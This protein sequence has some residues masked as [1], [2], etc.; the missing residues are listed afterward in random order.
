MKN[1]TCLAMLL[2]LI[3]AIS[4]TA[5]DETKP[6][7]DAQAE[8]DAQSGELTEPGDGDWMVDEAIAEGV[9]FKGSL[10]EGDPGEYMSPYEAASGLYDLV[11]KERL[12]KGADY[13]DS[14]PMFITCV[15][16]VEIEGKECYLLSVSGVFNTKA[17]EYGVDYDYD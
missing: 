6:G 8:S 14:E 1:K 5:C 17:W 9:I 4:L 13:S 7:D 16:V 15:D 2:I 12:N 10:L 11:L 3:L